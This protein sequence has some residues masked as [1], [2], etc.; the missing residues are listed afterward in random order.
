M[1]HLLSFAL[2]WFLLLLFLLEFAVKAG[3]NFHYLFDTVTNHTI[4]DDI[5]RNQRGTALSVAGLVVAG[6]ALLLTNNPEQYDVSIEIF[7][8]AFGF[9]LS[10]AF[11]HEL[12]L[13]KR[14][15]LTVQEMALEYGLLFLAYGFARIIAQIVPSASTTAYAVFI[16]ILIL[17]FASVPGEFRAHLNQEPDG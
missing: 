16:G 7:A 3:T 1:Q 14:I 15:V 5:S 9:L 11:A 17:R 12:T 2:Q 4:Y 8:A 10:A 6:L 13:T